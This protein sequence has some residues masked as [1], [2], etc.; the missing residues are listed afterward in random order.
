VTIAN[1]PL[2]NLSLPPGAA[3]ATFFF[4]VDEDRHVVTFDIIA[5]TRP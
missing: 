2:L 1:A 4:L 3:I 5:A